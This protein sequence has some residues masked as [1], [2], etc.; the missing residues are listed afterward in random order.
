MGV[1]MHNAVSINL[2]TQSCVMRSKPSYCTNIP[3][4]YCNVLIADC[5]QHS[6]EI[7]QSSPHA[8]VASGSLYTS[9]PQPAARRKLSSLSLA[10]A[11]AAILPIVVDNTQHKHMQRDTKYVPNK[12]KLH[13][14]TCKQTQNTCKHKIHT[15]L[16]DSG[17]EANHLPHLHDLATV[18]LQFLEQ[19]PV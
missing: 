11:A 1:R 3:H 16:T 8:V 12:H 9:C 15:N 10:T 7:R 2:V 4:L 6:E 13:K 18:S 14:N 17:Q 5:I 19:S